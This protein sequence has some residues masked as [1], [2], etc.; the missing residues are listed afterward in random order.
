MKSVHGSMASR[1]IVFMVGDLAFSHPTYPRRYVL[2]GRPA[3]KPPTKRSGN[4]TMDDIQDE[5]KKVKK[6][7]K[8]SAH[9][10]RHASAGVREDADIVTAAVA[11][12]GTAMEHAILSGILR[13]NRKVA[14]AAVQND[15][16]A[17]EHVAPML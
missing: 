9:A 8:K 14:L 1:S 6:K 13:G 5:K 11:R 3:S 12:D 16:R 2:E 4:E 7:V 15:G 17:L 10:L